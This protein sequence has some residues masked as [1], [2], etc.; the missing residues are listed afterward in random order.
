MRR[1]GADYGPQVRARL[2]FG[3][4][5]SA[6]DFHT[7]L[8]ARG[9][10][11]AKTL[12]DTYANADVTILPVLSDPLPTIAELDVSDS[13][14]MWMATGRMVKYTRPINYLG[15]PTIALPMP[16]SGSELPNGF[17]LIGRPFAEGRLLALGHAY[18]QELP[19]EV[20]MRLA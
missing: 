1:R 13:P 11:L 6:V 20:A 16:R 4:F 3:H 9:A 15:L 17:Q 10:W 12:A 19:P 5:V 2:E 7:A 18:Q 14:K 8:R